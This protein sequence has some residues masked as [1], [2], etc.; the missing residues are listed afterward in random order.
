MLPAHAGMVPRRP[1]TRSR[2]SSAPRALRGWHSSGECGSGGGDQV[3]SGL[4]SPFSRLL[5]R[6]RAVGGP[7]AVGGLYGALRRFGQL[8][9]QEAHSRSGAVTA[10]RIA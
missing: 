9:Q 7:H 1:T 8:G 4:E 3:V 6:G 5:E 2:G 10:D